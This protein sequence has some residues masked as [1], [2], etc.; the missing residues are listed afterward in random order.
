MR[1]PALA[2]VILAVASCAKL[3]ESSTVAPCPEWARDVAPIAQRQCLACHGPA[4]AEGAYR[5][6]SYLAA[7]APR[8]DG[9]P[10]AIPGDAANSLLVQAAAG[11]LS[12]H[13]FAEGEALEVLDAWVACRLPDGHN[14]YHPNGWSN[15]GDRQDF[16]GVALQKDASSNQSCRQCHGDDLRGGKS[17]VSCFQCHAGGPETGDGAGGCTGCHGDATSAAPPRDLSGSTDESRITVGAHRAH[18][19]ASVLRGPLACEECHLVPRHGQDPGHRDTAPPAEVF[20]MVDGV[21]PLARAEGAQPSFNREQGTCGSVYCHGGGAR[22]ARDATPGLVRVP[23][24][25][26]PPTS[27][28]YCGAC[29]GLPP[30]DGLHSLP[31]ALG[32]CAQCH[33]SSMSPDGGIR[34]SL[35]GAGRRASTHL[36]GVVQVGAAE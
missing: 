6:D 29:H 7:V 36:D 34:F 5:V 18:L 35:D 2:V 26:G 25:T 3:R 8:D 24:W 28:A 4:G 19:G 10:R 23:S 15:P 33:G 21:G 12:G 22:L 32:A 14:H 11:E 30:Q 13:P 27:Q 16:H 1:M 20:P 17:L 9:T 31:Q